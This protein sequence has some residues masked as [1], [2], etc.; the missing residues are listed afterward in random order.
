MVFVKFSLCIKIRGVLVY[1]DNIIIAKKNTKK[2]I[3][4]GIGISVSKAVWDG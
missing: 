3:D 1:N 2:R 4:W